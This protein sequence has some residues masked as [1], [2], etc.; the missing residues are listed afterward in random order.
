MIMIRVTQRILTD[1]SLVYNVSA[2]IDDI[3]VVSFD[4]AEQMAIKIRDAIEDHTNEEV[5]I[6]FDV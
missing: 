4:E 6:C 1:D 3:G 2:L 5:T